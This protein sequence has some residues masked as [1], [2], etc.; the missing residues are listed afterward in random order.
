MNQSTQCS[1]LS[2][3]STPPQASTQPEARGNTLTGAGQNPGRPNF[4]YTPAPE[5]PGITKRQF[6]VLL[7]AVCGGVLVIG[8]G[9]TRALFFPSNSS[10][11]QATAA[12]VLSPMQEQTRMMREAMNMAREA[13][14]M[15]RERLDMLREEMEY[16][17]ESASDEV[18]SPGGE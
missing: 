18:L 5:Q 7:G 11:A 12:P 8:F 2:A 6:N 4:S 9:I 14:E 3:N 17:R 13:Q 15:Q 10:P 16:N 1:P